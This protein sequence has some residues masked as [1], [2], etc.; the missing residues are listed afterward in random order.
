M[1]TLTKNTPLSNVDLRAVAEDSRCQHFRLVLLN[2]PSLF[3]ADIMV[4]VR[5]VFPAVRSG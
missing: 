3:R 5:T 2:T 4:V 1:K